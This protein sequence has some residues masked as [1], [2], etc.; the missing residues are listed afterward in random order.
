MSFGLIGVSLLCMLGTWQINR[1]KWKNNLINEVSTSI[2][3]EPQALNPTNIG[4]DSQYL[5]V[6]F[7]GKFYERLYG[8]THI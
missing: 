3:M 2:S 5:S 7:E 1:L 8:S 4:I 6:T